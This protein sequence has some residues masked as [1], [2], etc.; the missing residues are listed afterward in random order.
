[1]TR[2]EEYIQNAFNMF[3]KVADTVD[4]CGE[5]E[6]KNKMSIA[7]SN[8]QL[9]KKR[10]PYRKTIERHMQDVNFCQFSRTSTISSDKIII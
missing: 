9:G 5:S 6:L 10:G 3:Y 8:R 2:N 7:A 1:M 4:S